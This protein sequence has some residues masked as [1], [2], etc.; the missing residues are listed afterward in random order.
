M[1]NVLGEV[2]NLMPWV[3]NFQPLLHK[4][5]TALI[6]I[7]LLGLPL[8]YWNEDFI[9]NL[10][11]KIGKLLKMDERASTHNRGNFVRVCIKLNLEKP[12]R[13]GI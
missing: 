1:W 12:L 4:I 9:T 6:W 10:A 8:E 2:I 11:A 7:H 13:E 5:K 3:P